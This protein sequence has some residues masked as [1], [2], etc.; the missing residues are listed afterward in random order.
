MGGIY[1]SGDTVK[2]KEIDAI[3]KDIKNQ[4]EMQSKY[5]KYYD[6]LVR[7]YLYLIK[8]REKLKEDIDDK[9]IRYEFK[10]GNGIKQEK[11]NESVSHLIKVEQLLLKIV[12]DLGINNKASPEDPNYK[13]KQNGDD[14]EDDLL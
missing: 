5:G 2:K 1:E 3:E 14:V 12:N 4:L 11:P 7:D 8:T 9:G 13:S 10:N 6:D